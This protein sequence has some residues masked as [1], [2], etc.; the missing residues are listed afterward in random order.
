MIASEQPLASRI[1]VEILRKVGSAVDA[2]IATSA[3]LC[4]TELVLNGMA[5][6][7]S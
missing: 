6:A 5:P 2:A 4:L 3:M 1:G 7:R